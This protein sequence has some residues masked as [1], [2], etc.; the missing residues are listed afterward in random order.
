MGK[1]RHISVNIEEDAL[2]KFHYVSKYELRS[3]SA[4]IIFLINKCIREFEDEHGKIE[5]DESKA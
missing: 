3:A 5:L 4:Q 2:A 1:M